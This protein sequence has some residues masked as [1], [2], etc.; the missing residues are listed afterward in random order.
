LDLHHELHPPTGVYACLV[1]RLGAANGA[2]A[3]ALPAVANIGVRPTVDRAPGEAR[4][5]VHVL[6]FTGDLYGEQLEVAFVARLRPE[7]RFSDIEA[8]RTQI[9]L[10]VQ[11]A[12]E[13]LASDDGTGGGSRPRG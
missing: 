9:G 11:H 7:E 1:S 12:R 13:V 6:D 3:P 10:D 5:E 8:L 2:E 4:V